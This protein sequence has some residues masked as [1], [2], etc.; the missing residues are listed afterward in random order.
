MDSKTAMD[1]ELQAAFHKRFKDELER[2]A[3]SR[4]KGEASEMEIGQWFFSVMPQFIE[5]IFQAGKEVGDL[6]GRIAGHA[7]GVE[8]QKAIQI[9]IELEQSKLN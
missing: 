4:Q 5:D 3:L 7:K 9:R 2:I 8:D 1:K 6:E